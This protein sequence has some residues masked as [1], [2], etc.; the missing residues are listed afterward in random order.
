MSEC[1]I[2]RDL[3][4]T[5]FFASRE[6]GVHLLAGLGWV[7]MGIYRWKE[8]GIPT[9]THTYTY[10]QH[11]CTHA[12]QKWFANHVPLIRRDFVPYQTFSCI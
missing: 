4:T 5:Y 3:F 2:Y 12:E 1:G 7:R 6:G 10:T 9:H 11:V 8:K